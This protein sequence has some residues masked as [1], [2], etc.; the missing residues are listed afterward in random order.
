MDR[1]G[2][3]FTGGLVASEIVHCVKL[4]E[5]LGYDSAWVAEGHGGDQFAILAACAVATSRIRLGTSISSV[6][7]RSA[8][9]IAMAAATVDELSG[10]RFVL[11][12]GSS[13]RVQ[14][15]G[16]HGL[17]YARPIDRVRETVEV[18]RGLLRDGAVSFRGEVLDIPKFDLWFRPLRLSVPIYLSGLFRPM[19]EVCGE[20]AQGAIL[21]WSTPDFAHRAAAHVATGAQ[22][23]GRDATQVEIASLLGCAVG[24]DVDEARRRLKP[25]VALYAG[26]FPRYN[27]LLAESGFSEAAAA[28]KA[29]WDRGDRDGA[30]RL[31]PDALIDAVA[32]AGPPARCRERLAQYRAAGVGLPIVTP[33]V[34]DGGGTTAVTEAIRACAPA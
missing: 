14:V 11:G 4:A 12:L 8:P 30:V 21:T 26:F 2:V 1:V 20:L 22:R 29:A 25:G 3:A 18:V 10:G 28:I 19:L 13:H 34:R 32:L 27:R 9:T 17:P 33:R 6:F 5:D 31:V 24:A 15:A 16:E 7:V 23:A